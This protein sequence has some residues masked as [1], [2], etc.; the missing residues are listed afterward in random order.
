MDSCGGLKQYPSI[1]PSI[2]PWAQRRRCPMFPHFLTRRVSRL[3][4]LALVY[5]AFA[6]VGVHRLS[7]C[8]PYLGVIPS[9]RLHLPLDFIRVSSLRP[10]YLLPFGQPFTYSLLGE[11]P[12]LGLAL[13]PDVVVPRGGKV[14]RMEQKSRSKFLPWPG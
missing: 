2:D 12:G 14:V 9:T 13:V 3:L 6:R 10:T 4:G 8:L 7:L 11:F 1:H 5:W